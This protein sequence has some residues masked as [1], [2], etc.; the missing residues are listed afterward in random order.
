MAAAAR[1]LGGIEG[2]EAPVGR[3]HQA[4]GGGLGRER[5]LE[6][7]VGLEGDAGEIGHGA[8]EGADPALL[9]NHDGDRLALDQRLL[10]GREVVLGRLRKAGTALAERRLGTELVADRPDLLGNPLPLLLFRAD[11]VLERLALGAQILVLLPDLHL[12]ELAQIAQPHVED[13]VRLH[14]GQLE[15]LDQDRLGLVLAAD[16]LDDLVEV[17]I[18][19]QIAA[20]HLD[21]MIDLGRGGNSSAA[22]APRGGGR[23]TR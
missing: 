22:P 3:Q 9:G 6:L 11:Q 1:Q 7:V 18:G 2:V 15:G 20:E 10:H 16:D 8:L 23:A 4:L 14:I 13:G 21:P 17:E 19:H 12:L 5:E